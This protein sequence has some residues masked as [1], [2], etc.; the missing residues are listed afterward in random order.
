MGPLMVKPGSVKMRTLWRTFCVLVPGA[1]RR[2]AF[3]A[4]HQPLVG[5]AI[6]P[7]RNRGPRA[8]E[9]KEQDMMRFVWSGVLGLVFLGA[10]QVAYAKGC[11]SEPGDSDAVIAA[12]AAAEATCGPCDSA[13]NHGAYVSCVAGVAKSRVTAVLLPKTCAGAVKKCAA[14]STCGKPGFVTCCVTTGKGP[15]CKLKKDAASCEAKGGTATLTP[16]NTSCCSVSQPLTADACNASPSG[17]FV[18]GAAGC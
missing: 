13:A 6:V 8:R 10:T 12:R 5:V 4:C 1:R 17:A 11:G 9:R 7:Y 15:K 14:K 18:E 2:N 16:G 3:G